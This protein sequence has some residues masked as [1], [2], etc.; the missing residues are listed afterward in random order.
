[1]PK[2]HLYIYMKCNLVRKQDL[3]TEISE[4]LEYIVRA[5]LESQILNITGKCAFCS[6]YVSYTCISAKSQPV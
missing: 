1:M 6:M 3:I 2:A 4:D 5:D